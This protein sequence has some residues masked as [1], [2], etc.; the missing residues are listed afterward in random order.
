V[1]ESIDDLAGVQQRL[2]RG[3]AHFDVGVRLAR[4]WRRISGPVG[5][6]G[7]DERAAF[8]RKD[9]QKVK[10]TASVETT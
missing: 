8:V 4:A 5:P 2:E 3:E 1:Q 7:G 9:D 10:S 6:I